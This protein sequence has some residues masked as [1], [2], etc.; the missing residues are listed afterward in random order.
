MGAVTRGPLI[1]IV[2]PP[3]EPVIVG[4]STALTGPIGDR[5]SGY[6]DAVYA[7]IEHWRETNGD[8]IGGHEIEVRA[9]DDG[10]SEADITVTAARRHLG[11]TGLVGI[12]GPQCSSGSAAA[13]PIY[14][15]AGV[16]AISGSAT[17]TDLPA[18]QSPDGFFSR[19]A[20]RNDLE[21][22]L[23]ALFLDSLQ[24]DLVYSSRGCSAP[25]ATPP[26]LLQG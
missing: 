7:G 14:Q 15:D 8:R 9:E 16:V 19:S 13:L 4:V 18:G 25:L 1:P 22:T 24:A 12:I 21:G 10:C 20:Y 26:G 17:R 2:I 3:D 5:G 11:R 6:L 23:I